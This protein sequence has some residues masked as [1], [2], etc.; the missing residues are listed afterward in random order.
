MA[1]GTFQRHELKYLIDGR[2]R[3]AL[4]RAMEPYMREDEYGESTICSLYYDTPDF[5]LVRRSLEKPDY[6]EKLRLRSY[7]MAK[8]EGDIFVE[9]KKKYGGIVYKR[10]ISMVER[11]A[12]A[13]LAGGE[14]FA[15][16]SQIGR[17]IRWFRDFYG[18]LVP[19]MVLCYDRVAH[20]CPA[21]ADLRITFDR[22]IRWRVGDLSLTR[23]A[24]GEPLLRPGWS[25]LEIKASSAMPLWLTHALSENRIRQTSFSKYGTAYTVVQERNKLLKGDVHCA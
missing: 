2:Q 9:L 10:R 12:T 22:N 13:W 3:R 15:P 11:E 25:L 6:K 18:E 16:D 7:G 1:N 23:P 5:R 21:D 4:E 20:F 8:P 19:A 14:V 17:E 24:W